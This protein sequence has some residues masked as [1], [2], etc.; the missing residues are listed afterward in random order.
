MLSLRSAQCCATDFVN[1]RTEA[2][3]APYAIANGVARSAA[4]D[5]MLTI[6]PPPEVWISGIALLQPRKTPS[7]FTENIRLQSLSVDVSGFAFSLGGLRTP[8]L[9]T[10]TCSPPQVARI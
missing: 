8:A 4:T 3:L 5:D 7:T 6:E 10:R 9:L 2:L 1:C